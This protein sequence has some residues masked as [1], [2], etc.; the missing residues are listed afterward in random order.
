MTKDR[1]FIKND[2]FFLVVGVY[3]G[4][5][6]WLQGIFK[7][8]PEIFVPEEKELFYFTRYFNRGNAWYESFFKRKK[9]EHIVGEVC[10]SYLAHSSFAAKRIKDY[11]PKSKIIAI[12]RDPIHQIE[13]MLRL[14]ANQRGQ[15]YVE[16]LSFDEI[17]EKYLPNVMYYS[18]L[19]PFIDEFEKDNI[20]ILDYN[21]LKNSQYEFLKIIYNFLGTQ[22]Y[23]PGM[24]AKVNMSLKPKSPIISIMISKTGDLLRNLNLYWL[25]NLMKRLKIV[26][27]LKELNSSNN[28]N[29]INLPDNYKDKIKLLLAEDYKKLDTYTN[30]NF[31]RWLS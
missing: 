9:D 11:N 28:N 10:P 5:T 15:K 20:L 29:Y 19:K 31:S 21:F 17:I 3:R 18:R 12:L 13:S 25:K 2:N 1:G 26:E 8:H 16:Q 4:G 14:H 24:D 30:M 22:T 7:N 6:T 27:S 23:F